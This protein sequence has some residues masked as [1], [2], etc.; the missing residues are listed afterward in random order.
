MGKTVADSYIRN[1]LLGLPHDVPRD[2]SNG[3]PDNEAT[4]SDCC[5][6]TI[7]VHREIDYLRRP[8]RIA[9]VGIHLGLRNMSDDS[10]QVRLTV[11]RM[12]Q[13]E[14]RG[15]AILGIHLHVLL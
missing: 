3:V 11:H 4:L 7:F 10:V 2:A 12:C 6:A 5:K 1:C 13:K 8:P 14:P 9:V 15:D